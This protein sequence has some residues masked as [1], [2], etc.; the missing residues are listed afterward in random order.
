MTS[1]SF[2]ERYLE[3]L[4]ID[5][6]KD[7]SE[8]KAAHARAHEIRKFE[9]DLYWKR[10]AYFWAFQLIAFTA[11]GLLLRDGD[12]AQ[13]RLLL[14]PAGIGAVTAFAG[15]LTARGSKFWQENWEAH[16]DLLEGE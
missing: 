7:V 5:P 15:Y 4:D 6:V 8:L 3:A 9:I 16:V 1:P 13:T 2:R 11:L 14:I 12:F 10:A